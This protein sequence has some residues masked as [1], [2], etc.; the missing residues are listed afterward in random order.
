MKTNI[1]ASMGIL[2]LIINIIYVRANDNIIVTVQNLVSISFA[3]KLPL[4]GS[5]IK[6]GY[7]VSPGNDYVSCPAL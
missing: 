4:H 5:Y 3:A 2:T 7:C 6:H 1:A